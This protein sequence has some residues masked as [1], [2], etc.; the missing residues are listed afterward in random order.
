[1][2]IAHITEGF[3]LDVEYHAPCPARRHCMAATRNTNYYEMALVHP[4]GPC[5]RHVPAY[6]GDYAEQLDSVDSEGCVLVPD[7]PGLGVGV[8]WDYIVD[9]EI[10]RV[11]FGS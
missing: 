11:T 2:K 5:T 3:G 10:D 6:E 8:D 7:G 1:M 4:D 9:R